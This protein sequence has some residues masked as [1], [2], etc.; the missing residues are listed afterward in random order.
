M[1]IS[2]WS[3][4]VCSSDL[5]QLTRLRAELYPDDEM[6]P[7]L[8]AVHFRELGAAMWQS[9]TFPALFD[10]YPA[11]F[12]LT[13]SAEIEEAGIAVRPDVHL[14]RVGPE[15]IDLKSTRLNSSH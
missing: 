10:N 4:D 13:V 15:I 1:R 12:Y 3:S 7:S 14:A 6:M 2:D 9:V 5:A 8:R 11:E